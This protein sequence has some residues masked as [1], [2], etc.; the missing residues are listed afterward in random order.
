MNII[1][2]DKFKSKYRTL[3]DDSAKDAI[4][5]FFNLTESSSSLSQ[6]SN[7]IVRYTDGI[8]GYR[9]KTYYRVLFA[10]EGHNMIVLDLLDRRTGY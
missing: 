10:V 9:I 6:L 8:L 5:K 3:R 4:V 2:E 7:H 1:L